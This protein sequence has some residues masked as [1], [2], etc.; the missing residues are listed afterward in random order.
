[1]AIEPKYV[2][3]TWSATSPTIAYGVFI[4]MTLLFG[5]V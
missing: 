2:G 1:M 5:D 3:A 4:D